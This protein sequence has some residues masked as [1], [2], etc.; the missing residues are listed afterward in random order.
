M[1]E[2]GTETPAERG[3]RAFY[4]RF[5]GRSPRTRTAAPIARHSGAHAP[6]CS[7]S[8]RRAYRCRRPLERRGQGW[9]AAARPMVL[10]GPWERARW[11]GRTPGPSVRHLARSRLAG[12]GCAPTDPATL[13]SSFAEAPQPALRD[14]SA[15]RRLSWRIARLARSPPLNSRESEAAFLGVAALS[16][17]GPTLAAP[18]SPRYHSMAL[19]CLRPR[20]AAPV[21]RSAGSTSVT[22]AARERYRRAALAGTP[23]DEGGGVR[24]SQNAGAPPGARRGRQRRQ[25]R[26]VD[27]RSIPQ[28]A[29]RGSYSVA[30]ASAPGRRDEA[31]GRTCCGSRETPEP[32]EVP[33]GAD[34]PA[35]RGFRTGLDQ[36]LHCHVPGR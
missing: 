1:I 21:R 31:V 9:P 13:R 28:P 7:G 19:G 12:G 20:L 17:S 16:S 22:E 30:P 10:P 34:S 33:P 2:P 14:R 6:T 24:R 4:G 25:A 11:T 3:F 23:L 35:L 8:S 36:P 26:S 15:P 27:V 32:L 29:G 5:A 18:R